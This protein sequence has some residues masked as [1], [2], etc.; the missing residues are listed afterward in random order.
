MK[1]QKGVILIVCLWVS[2]LVIWLATSTATVFR[3]TFSSEAALVSHFRARYAALG[4][5][6]EALA[7]MGWGMAQELEL[8]D[9][10]QK[11]WRPDGTVHGLDYSSCAVVV[12]VEDEEAKININVVDEGELKR[13]LTEKVGFSEETAGMWAERIMD[14]IDGDDSPRDRGAEAGEYK[15]LGLPYGPPN[16]PIKHIEELLLIPGIEWEDFWYGIEKGVEDEPLPGRVSPFSLFTVYGNR[17]VLTE[18]EN[19]NNWKSGGLYRIVSG[20]RCGDYGKAVIY[21]VVKLNAG[22]VPPYGIVEIKEML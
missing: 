19:T 13:V 22:A 17:K 1:G 9:V 8:E 2:G 16:R 7:R 14:F 15:E 5:I 12:R 10:G 18:A 20:A 11:G 3:F 21:A 6:Q 4:G